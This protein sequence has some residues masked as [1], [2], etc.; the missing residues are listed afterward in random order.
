MTRCL[1][2]GIVAD[3]P[4][5]YQSDGDGTEWRDRKE[6]RR[7]LVRRAQSRAEEEETGEFQP[8]SGPGTAMKDP[9]DVAEVHSRSMVGGSPVMETH[10]NSEGSGT[11][12]SAEGTQEASGEDAADTDHCWDKRGGSCLEGSNQDNGAAG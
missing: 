4:Q 9:E 7:C 12:W 2:S 8:P 6:M 11:W 5:A 10:V 3:G 1:S